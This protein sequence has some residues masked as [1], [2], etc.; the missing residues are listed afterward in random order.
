MIQIA[1]TTWRQANRSTVIRSILLLTVIGAS[2]GYCGS[3][4][5]SRMSIDRRV[6]RAWSSIVLGAIAIAAYLPALRWEQ[7]R[8]ARSCETAALTSRF[9]AHWPIQVWGAAAA[10]SGLIAI[11]GLLPITW[12]SDSLTASSLIGQ[13]FFLAISA[14]SIMSALAITVASFTPLSTTLLVVTSVGLLG[15]TRLD[16]PQEGPGSLPLGDVLSIILP[17][18]RVLSMSLNPPG[19]GGGSPSTWECLALAASAS[20]ACLATTIGIARFRWN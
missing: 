18:I 8:R 14:V 11:M 10:Y 6:E 16:H 15:V 17:P 2:V 1:Q 7:L 13:R 20:A 3:I 12:L 4:F 9:A 5:E 19:Q